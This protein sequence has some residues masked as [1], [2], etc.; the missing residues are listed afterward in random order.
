M[1]IDCYLIVQIL[2]RFLPAA[3][4][5]LHL[6]RLGD[7]GL[8]VDDS[9]LTPAPTRWQR[10]KVERLVIRGAF[11]RAEHAAEFLPRPGG[12]VGAH[13]LEEGWYFPGGRHAL[14]GWSVG[15][16][17]GVQP[18]LL[19]VSACAAAAFQSAGGR[20]TAQ[21]KSSRMLQKQSLCHLSDN[22]GTAYCLSC[23][24]QTVWNCL[25]MSLN[26]PAAS[27]WFH[28]SANK[29][30]ERDL[31]SV[32]TKILYRQQEEDVSWWWDYLGNTQTPSLVQGQARAVETSGD[33]CRTA[34]SPRSDWWGVSDTKVWGD[35]AISTKESSTKVTPIPTKKGAVRSAPHPP[36]PLL[37]VPKSPN[38]D[39]WDDTW[40]KLITIKIQ[41]F[42]VAWYV[43]LIDPVA[44]VGII[45]YSDTILFLFL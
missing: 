41:G 44:H 14:S 28:S 27:S 7:V 15:G 40:E 32:E 2:Q 34:V 11:H 42:L 45:L 30:R 20:T 8:P 38:I 16:K 5:D 9:P 31:L 18:L 25:L 33:R 19:I 3:L 12:A 26:E 39:M 13:V 35:Y 43:P 37:L 24:K 23:Y 1:K 22:M 36:H 29:E 10:V 6:P 17:N 4:P 21:R